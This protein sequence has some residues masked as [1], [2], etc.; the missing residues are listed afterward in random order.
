MGI[1]KKYVE[2][3]LNKKLTLFSALSHGWLTMEDDDDEVEAAA[4]DVDAVKCSCVSISDKAV[5]NCSCLIEGIKG[6]KSF[7]L[8]FDNSSNSMFAN[9]FVMKF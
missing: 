2:F 9:V 6:K 4:A 8:R 5:S 3:F 7:L 1:Y